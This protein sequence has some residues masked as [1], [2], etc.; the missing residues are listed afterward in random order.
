MTRPQFFPRHSRWTG[1]GD[2]QVY[3]GPSNVRPVFGFGTRQPSNRQMIGGGCF[4]LMGIMGH[5][6]VQVRRAFCKVQ[7]ESLADVVRRP[8]LGVNFNVRQRDGTQRPF[9]QY[10][11]VYSKKTE[12]SL[13]EYFKYCVNVECLSLHRK[14]PTYAVC[15]ATWRLAG[16]QASTDHLLVLFN[17]F[18]HECNFDIA[19]HNRGTCV[20]RRPPAPVL[21]AMGKMHHPR[22]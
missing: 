7:L 3:L 20:R 19:P 2:E 18:R 8:I 9:V 13:Y 11:P 10:C 22:I 16:C 17:S 12:R 15:T 4:S 1:R 21:V 5:A 6:S 14:R